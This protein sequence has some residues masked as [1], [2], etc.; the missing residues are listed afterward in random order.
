[1]KLR[2]FCD[3][4]GTV[5]Q[6]DV[7][8]LIFTTF[9]DKDH[10]WKLVKEWRNG[11]LEGREMWRKQAAI[12]RMTPSELEKFAAKQTIDPTFPEFVS[13]CKN[14]QIPVYIVSDGMDAY[15]SRILKHNGLDDLVVRSNH[16]EMSST[17]ILKVDFPYYENG[18][19]S[20]ANCKGLHVSKETKPGEIS[21]YI[22]DGYSDKCALAIADIT[23]AKD[24]LLLYC[25]E[26]NFPFKPFE[27][28][29]QVQ[30]ELQKLL[31][32]DPN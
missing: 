21:V 27:D 3:F 6:N 12:M 32:S 31:N 10:Y 8:D 19:G 11:E 29:E 9:G 26:K 30:N 23:F 24:D 25:Q 14:N 18:C 17:G 22:G 15:I 28:F 4:D 1:M 5:A 20:C 16:L 13:F 7:G 2:V